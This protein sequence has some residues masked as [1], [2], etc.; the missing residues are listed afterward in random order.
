MSAAE[1]AQLQAVLDVS[2][3]EAIACDLP[4][5]IAVSMAQ[6]QS[7][8]SA[9]APPDPLPQAPMLAAPVDD[10]GP[11]PAADFRS[12]DISDAYDVAALSPN[13]A[14][15]VDV[16][17]EGMTFLMYGLRSGRGTNP[18]RDRWAAHQAQAT[19]SAD[20]AWPCC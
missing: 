15:V 7:V 9:M 13:D 19:A 16:P 11:Q 2:Q 8:M 5:G 18:C 20:P 12:Y 1:Q 6:H 3:Q 10:L 4:A 14:P 17:V